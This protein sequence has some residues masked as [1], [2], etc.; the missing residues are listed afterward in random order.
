MEFEKEV[1]KYVTLGRQIGC[2]IACLGQD[3][4]PEGE[5][6]VW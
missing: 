1:G 5:V 4:L 3:S 6:G 2:F